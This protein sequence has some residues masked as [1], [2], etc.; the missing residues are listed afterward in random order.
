[1]RWGDSAF[2]SWCI[3]FIWSPGATRRLCGNKSGKLW[4]FTCTHTKTHTSTGRTGARDCT[5]SAQVADKFSRFLNAYIPLAAPSWP[6][7][8]VSLQSLHSPKDSQAGGE[9]PGWR[10]DIQSFTALTGEHAEMNQVVFVSLD[11]NACKAGWLKW[12]PLI[13]RKVAAE[14]TCL[15]RVTFFP[16]ARMAGWMDFN[17]GQF[18]LSRGPITVFLESFHYLPAGRDKLSNSPCV[19]YRK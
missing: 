11:Q 6:N 15:V 17:K 18:N 10:G 7:L 5:H 1:M 8:S 12:G 14:F 3:V 9:K 4:G 19:R 2:D 16:V 13:H